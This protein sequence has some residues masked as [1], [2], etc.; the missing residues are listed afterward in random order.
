MSCLV[1]PLQDARYDGSSIDS[2][3]LS[4]SYPSVLMTPPMSPV[5]RERSEDDLKGCKW[6]KQEEGEKKGRRGKREGYRETGRTACTPL[7]GGTA[8]KSH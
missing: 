2:L 6:G 1:L 3:C 8:K 4:P 7:A 5:V